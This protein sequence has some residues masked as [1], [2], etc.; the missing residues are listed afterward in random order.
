MTEFHFVAFFK[1][2]Q[3]TRSTSTSASNFPNKAH[4]RRP[5]IN[6]TNN[7][8]GKSQHR[9]NNCSSNNNNNNSSSRS[10]SN[11]NDKIVSFDMECFKFTSLS[12]LFTGKII[13]S[14]GSFGVKLSIF[15]AGDEFVGETTYTF[16]SNFKE[17]HGEINQLTTIEQ[18]FDENY[19]I[20]ID[21][22]GKKVAM[23]FTLCPGDEDILEAELNGVF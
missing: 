16:M 5:L 8:F 22:K 18:I 6:D 7:R 15:T 11:N 1:T 20:F 21:Y 2:K 23:G 17:C 13:L 19:L 14:R 3:P 4:V 12:F 9:V 10:S